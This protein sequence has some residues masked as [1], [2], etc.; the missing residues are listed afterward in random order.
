MN[1][2]EA[3][4]LIDQFTKYAGIMLRN[5]ELDLVFAAAAIAA[6]GVLFGISQLLIPSILLFGLPARTLILTLTIG[7]SVL[8]LVYSVETTHRK[9]E[10]F[11]KRLLLLED[12]RSKYKSLPDT[13]TLNIIESKKREP[14][15]N[16]LE[17]AERSI[18]QRGHL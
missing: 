1:D 9:Y 5:G 10:D 15:R 7:A 4:Y 17:E 13:V 3:R 12:Y 18:M 11:R 2:D 6:V 8:L 14:L 16:L